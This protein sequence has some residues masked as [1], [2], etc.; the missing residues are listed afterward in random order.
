MHVIV[1]ASAKGGVG[2]TTLTAH[3]AVAAMAAGAGPV[4]LVDTDPQGSLADWWNVRAAD[5]P[6]FVSASLDTLPDTLDTLRSRGAGVVLIDTPPAVTDQ[7]GRIVAQAGLVLIPVCASP[8]DLRAVGR[9]VDLVEAAGRPFVFILT[10]VKPHARLTTAAAT[11][12]SAHGTVAPTL[13]VDRV[14][15]AASMTDGRTVLEAAPRG[16]AAVEMADLW[17]FVLSCITK[18][19]NARK[20]ARTKPG[21]AE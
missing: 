7:I 5:Q 20:T 16:A 3:L 8:H 11:A 9:T 6:A 13:V 12:L 19:T 4:A 17:S 14:D 10:R 21:K 18:S 2:K 15:Y 1:L